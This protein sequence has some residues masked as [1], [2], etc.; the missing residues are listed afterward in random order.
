MS[1][2]TSDRLQ[3]ILHSADLAKSHI[4]DLNAVELAGTGTARDATLFRLA[5]VCEA[6][7]RLA[8]EV[9]ALAPEIPWRK[10]RAMRTYIVHGYWQIDFAVVVDTIE[11]DLPVLR[12]AASRLI[13][14]IERA[15]G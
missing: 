10:I 15:D 1:R 5:V 12:A 4:G 3:D 7:T 9:Q 8:P 11:R 6:A 13:G 2:S 14:T